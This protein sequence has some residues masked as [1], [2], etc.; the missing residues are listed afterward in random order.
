M[1]GYLHENFVINVTLNNEV[2][3]E[4][5]KSS[6]S[7]DR[8]LDTDSGSRPDFPWSLT[9]FVYNVTGA[10]FGIKILMKSRLSSGT[11]SNLEIVVSDHH[12][13]GGEGVKQGKRAKYRS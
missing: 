10:P 8:T 4:F 1:I 12:R 5:R 13:Y 3:V 2:P 7:G 6:G 11:E 9:A